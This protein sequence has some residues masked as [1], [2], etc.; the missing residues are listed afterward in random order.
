VTVVC[1]KHSMHTNLPY[2]KNDDTIGAFG[3]NFHVLP[4][5]YQYDLQ[6]REPIAPSVKKML[7]GN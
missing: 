2:I 4:E 3:V 7:E 5:G 1:A 6:K